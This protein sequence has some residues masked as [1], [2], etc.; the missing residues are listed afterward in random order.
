[1]RA[2]RST[3]RQQQHLPDKPL[4]QPNLTPKTVEIDTSSTEH[5]HHVNNDT[6]MIK[7][8]VTRFTTHESSTVIPPSP[9]P[10]TEQ[11]LTIRLI[12]PGRELPDQDFVTSP[13]ITIGQLTQRITAL[14]VSPSLI[15]H[16]L[17]RESDR[18]QRPHGRDYRG[19]GG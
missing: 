13:M 5:L 15:A 18:E 14:F 2:I 8:S 12:F 10:M 6:M 9:P 1:M 3:F 16:T 17:L 19:Q 4:P 11:Y 7:Q